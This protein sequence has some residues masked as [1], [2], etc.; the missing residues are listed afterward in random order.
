MLTSGV[1][2]SGACVELAMQA[3][4]RR[5]FPHVAVLVGENEARGDT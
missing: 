5:N 3:E 1:L 4:V 2:E